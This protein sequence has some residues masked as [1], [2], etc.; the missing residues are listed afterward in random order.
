MKLIDTIK[1]KID[2]TIKYVFESSGSILEFSYINKNDGKDIIVVPTQTSCNLG[3]KFCFLTGLNIK[4]R[5]LSVVEI[6]MGVMHVLNDLDKKHD[7]LLVSYMGCGEPLLAI[8]EVI[9]ASKSIHI[10]YSPHY[11]VVR[12]AVASLIPSKDR[13]MAFSK[14][15]LDTGLKCKFHYSMHTTDDKLRKMLMP[16]ATPIACDEKWGRTTIDM[17]DKYV[18]WSENS[19]EV[20]YT[21]MSGIN[22]SDEDANNI[23]KLLKSTKISVKL[24]R[25]SEKPGEAIIGSNNHLRFKKILEDGG[26]TTE[27]YEPP[28]NDVGAS[29]GQFLLEY[30]TKY[31]NNKKV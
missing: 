31:E 16:A 28:G 17:I 27:Y 1:S 30:Y 29:C 24:L 22:D 26:I 21:L 19:A 4:V 23:I 2:N 25:L 11:K 18:Q 7:V 6:N 20:H 3:C 15:I 14:A 13:F 12:F 10:M 9:S 5:N 8:D